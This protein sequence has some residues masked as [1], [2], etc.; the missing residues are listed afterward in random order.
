MSDS[1]RRREEG[2][3]EIG[4]HVFRFIQP[5]DEK[6]APSFQITSIC[7][8][9]PGAVFFERGVRNF[10]AF[11]RQARVARNEHLIRFGDNAPGGCH[12]FRRGEGTCL[13]LQRF[14]RPRKLSGL[15]IAIA[16]RERRF[17]PQLEED[18]VRDVQKHAQTLDYCGSGECFRLNQQGH[19]CAE[20]L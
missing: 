14:L 7:T 12:G 2:R 9:R 4:E 11:R 13:A 3:V 6:K 17:K 16:E 1:Q 15:A 5:P 19:T 8:I 18:G 20:P 10:K